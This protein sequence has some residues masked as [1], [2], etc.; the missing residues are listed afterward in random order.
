MATRIMTMPASSGFS[1]MVPAPAEPILLCAQPVARAGSPMAKAA[2]RA[3]SPFS[4][5]ASWYSRSFLFK[6]PVRPAP[7]LVELAEELHRLE[8][9]G[10]YGG[11]Q[12]AQKQIKE[13]DE[14]RDDDSQ[15]NIV[16]HLA[17]PVCHK[18]HHDGCR[19]DCHKTH[20]GDDVTQGLYELYGPEYALEDDQR[21]KRG[22]HDSGGPGHQGLRE[23]A[24]HDADQ[25]QERD[26]EHKVDG[27]G[28]GLFQGPPS[29][30]AYDADC[31][32]KEHMPY[33]YGEGYNNKRLQRVYPVEEYGVEKAGPLSE[34]A[35][36]FSKK[37]AEEYC[38]SPAYDEYGGEVPEKAFSL[39]NEPHP[40]VRGRCEYEDAVT[41]VSHYE[42]EKGRKEQG[43]ERRRVD[44]AVLRRRERSQ[45]NLERPYEPRVFYID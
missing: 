39:S 13:M 8:P 36:E 17:H 35:E 7:S 45:K 24:E 26:D 29:R 23:K 44:R 42:A 25:A 37:E 38:R 6:R 34:V 28:A 21:D 20:I 30:V 33:A 27:L 1:A 3:M 2:A 43:H 22:C 41:H 40:Q 12:Y 9:H 16:G 15:N 31:Y 19:A 18:G 14:R 10:L 32:A 11:A 4:I 5:Y